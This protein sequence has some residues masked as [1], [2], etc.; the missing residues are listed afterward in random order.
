MQYDEL[1]LSALHLVDCEDLDVTELL[2]EP[3]L[4][5]VLAV[6]HQPVA[7]LVDDV[8][9]GGDLSDVGSD[10]A[11]V[12]AV[13]ATL[14]L[15]ADAEHDLADSGDGGDDEAVVVARLG[16]VE[17]LSLAAELHE[18]DALA[19]V[20]DLL[21]TLGRC[22]GLG[23]M[24]DGVADAH[25]AARVGVVDQVDD[26]L[27]RTVLLPE[28]DGLHARKYPALEDG[29]AVLLPERV[30][31]CIA[32]EDGRRLMDVAEQDVRNMRVRRDL[33]RT[34]AG[35]VGA[36]EDERS[37]ST[38]LGRLASLVVQDSE[39]LLEGVGAGLRDDVRCH[40]D[41]DG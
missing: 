26:V 33:E 35:D 38:H 14:A 30:V 39:R 34:A 4:V 24:F 3:E 20:K 6:L 22:E 25:P 21:G 36:A 40:A 32:A 29:D 23:T 19:R 10:D 8:T 15:V 41:G 7:V 2:T 5:A 11:N 12:S 9:I 1:L 17:D 16:G 18:D 27:V 31:L 28:P 13:E 37:D